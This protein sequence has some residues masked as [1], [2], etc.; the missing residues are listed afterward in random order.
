MGFLERV[1][2]RAL[3]ALFADED[4]SANDAD[5]DYAE[6]DDENVT[7]VTEKT[8]FESGDFISKGVMLD[9][10]IYILEDQDSAND[11]DYH[12]EYD[13]FTDDELDTYYEEHGY[14][15]D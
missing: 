9:G 1:V 6:R 11:D 10:E 2:D 15:D 4:D 14:M 12:D 8:D 5:D 3:D 13:D 7:E